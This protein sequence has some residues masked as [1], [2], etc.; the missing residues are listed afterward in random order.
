MHLHRGKRNTTLRQS[1]PTHHD[2]DFSCTGGQTYQTP[3]HVQRQQPPHCW[4]RSNI[5]VSVRVGCDA[6]NK[7]LHMGSR[8]ALIQCHSGAQQRM[9]SCWCVPGHLHWRAM[10][11]AAA[12]DPSTTPNAGLSGSKFPTG[13]QARWCLGTIPVERQMFDSVAVIYRLKENICCFPLKVSYSQEENP[14]CETRY[15]KWFL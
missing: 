14:A 10:L 13:F 3:A 12:P 8:D 6:I 9:E 7:P 11:T 2:S 15:L 4:F 1:S 5:E